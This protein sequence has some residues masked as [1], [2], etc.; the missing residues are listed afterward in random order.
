MILCL[1][2]NAE[3]HY[4]LSQTEPHHCNGFAAVHASDVQFLQSSMMIDPSDIGL[5]FAFAFGTVLFFWS[6]GLAYRWAT[7][8]IKIASNDARSLENG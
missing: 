4:S 7:T 3:G 6:L 8:S 1:T 5:T 2:P